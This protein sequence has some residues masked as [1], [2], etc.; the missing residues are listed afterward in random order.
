MSVIFGSALTSANV[1]NAFVSRINGTVIETI[2]AATTGAL[3]TMPAPSPT[4]RLTNASLV[5]IQT[6]G[7]FLAGKILIISNNTG[8]SITIKDGSG[9]IL[10]GTG[11]DLTVADEASIILTGDS[12]SGNFYKVVGGS[13]GGGGAST[14]RAGVDSLT[15]S[16]Q[17]HSIVFSST[18]GT[19][20]YSV[21]VCMENGTDTDSLLWLKW[22]IQNKSATGFDVIFD[23]PMNSNNY[24]L[25]WKADVYA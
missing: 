24:K 20:S 14:Y 5:S 11:S 6:I 15:T 22:S 16:T 8:S 17:T 2:D 4:V 18:I 3:A 1:N 13:G 12:N 19:A 25:N 7:N 23:Q 21:S 9:N 10:T